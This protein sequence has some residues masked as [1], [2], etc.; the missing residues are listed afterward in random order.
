MG[1][2]DGVVCNRFREWIKAVLCATGSGFESHKNDLR[3][4]EGFQPLMLLRYIREFP[5]Q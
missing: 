3:C 4:W 5:A 2:G 1:K